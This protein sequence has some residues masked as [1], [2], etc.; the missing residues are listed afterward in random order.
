[1]ASLK[2]IALLAGVSRATVCYALQGHPKISPQTRRLVEQAAE[3]LQY[4]PDPILSIAGSR[5]WQRRPAVNEGN[6]AFLS[7]TLPTESDFIRG[8]RERAAQLGYPLDHIGR[9]ELG[10]GKRAT[11]ILLNRGIKGLIVGQLSSQDEDW[12]LDWS[13]FAVV[14]C[15]LG[16]G[17]LPYDVVR[18]DLHDAV[19]RAF[20]ILVE[21]GYRRIGFV[22]Y[23]AAISPNDEEIESAWL[24]AAVQ[25]YG[26]ENVI[27][28]YRNDLAGKKKA[29]PFRSWLKAWR[30]DALIGN[31]PKLQS[32]L[33]ENGVQCPQDMAVITLRANGI[34][35]RT[36]G[37]VFDANH[38]GSHAIDYLDQQLHRN[39]RGL[40]PL[41][42]HMLIRMPWCE[43]ETTYEKR[44][45]TSGG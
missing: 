15:A 16:Y 14:G 44:Q 26:L 32:L 10:T 11:E 21:K 25:A 13:H 39:D 24:F 40:H 4:R 29:G 2:D 6:L 28:A 1:M 7:R 5:R 8:A 36:S 35:K 27:P 9:N 34:E 45:Q 37:F 20:R 12:N 22:T 33:N 43:G 42:Y 23:S 18:Y 38:L 17:E 30:P 31:I 3:Q 19:R 41:P